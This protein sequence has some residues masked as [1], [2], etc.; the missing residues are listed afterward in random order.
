V[1][2]EKKT[3][4]RELHSRQLSIRS[5]KKTKTERLLFQVTASTSASEDN[6]SARSRGC[7]TTEAAVHIP[8]RSVT[9]RQVYREEHSSL[10][11]LKNPPTKFNSLRNEVK[12]TIERIVLEEIARDT[13]SNGHFKNEAENN[14]C[15]VFYIFNL[16][17]SNFKRSI[18]K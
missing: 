16:H 2:P 14:Y 15:Y 8:G 10:T 4:T 12:W 3:E 9:V 6:S 1:K 18:T 11:P 13:T 7:I 5:T 17:N